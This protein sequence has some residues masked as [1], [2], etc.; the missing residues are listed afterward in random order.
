QGAAN[1]LERA[2]ALLPPGDRARVDLALPRSQCLFE[3]G[4]YGRCEEVLAEAVDEAA[5]L[6]DERLEMHLRAQHSWMRSYWA[7]EGFVQEAEEIA[8]RALRIFEG[9]SDE[10]GQARAWALVAA[11]L[12]MLGHASGTDEAW[13][14]SLHHARRAGDRAAERMALSRLA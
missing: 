12:H 4:E 13:E 8:T 14:R 9:S 7:P 3:T 10:L 1:L 11:R 6:D 5:H 2:R